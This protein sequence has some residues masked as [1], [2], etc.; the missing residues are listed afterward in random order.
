MVFLVHINR[1]TTPSSKNKAKLKTD[2]DLIILKVN[3]L[4][5]LHKNGKIVC[6]WP[7]WEQDFVMQVTTIWVTFVHNF[8]TPLKN[9]YYS[10]TKSW[11][12]LLVLGFLPKICLWSHHYHDTYYHFCYLWI[13]PSKLSSFKETEI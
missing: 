8:N 3:W 1:S 13:T 6:D 5:K 7:N 12:R 10:S 11:S 4:E 2:T 9:D